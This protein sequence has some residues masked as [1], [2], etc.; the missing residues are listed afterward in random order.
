MATKLKTDS[1]Y[2]AVEAT[3]TLGSPLLDRIGYLLA[4][5]HVAV[6]ELGNEVLAPL[7]LDVISFGSLLVLDEH[8]TL[9]QQGLAEAI[10]CDRTTMVAIVD[11]LEGSGYVERRRNPSDRRAYALEIT[12]RGREALSAASALVEGVEDEF[13]APLSA[14]ERSSL[15]DLLRRLLVR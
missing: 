14:G 9:S 7:G 13:L 3:N 8:G 15:R 5:T 12:D 11:R 4:K 2:P 6:R 1:E 10:R